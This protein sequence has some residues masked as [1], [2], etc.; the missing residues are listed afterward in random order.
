[1]LAQELD[2]PPHITQCFVVQAGI[3]LLEAEVHRQALGV[4]GQRPIARRH[5]V[6]GGHFDGLYLLPDKP[7]GGDNG[8]PFG[9][10]GKLHKRPGP[11]CGLARRQVEVQTP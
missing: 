1:M 2:H 6:G 10:L 11:R 8:L 7:A 5:V 4:A 9:A 3:A